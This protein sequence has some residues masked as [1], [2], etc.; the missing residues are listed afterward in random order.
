MVFDLKMPFTGRQNE[1]K[2]LALYDESPGSTLV[3]IRGRRRI[4]KS[5]LVAEY[6]KNKV[7]IKFSGIAPE[8]GM[9]AKDQREHFVDQFQEQFQGSRLATDNWNHLFYALAEK[10]KQNNIVLL[11]D[12]ISWMAHDDAT[13]LSKL[14]DF[15]DDQV[16]LNQGILFVL[17]SSVS[18]WVDENILGGKAFYGRVYG[19]IT[20]GELSL[21]QSLSLLAARGVRGSAQELLYILSIT[22][23]VPWY[24]ELFSAAQSVLNNISRLCFEKGGALVKEFDRIFG[25]LFSKRKGIYRDIVAQ[26]VSGKLRQAELAKKLNYSNSLR[27]GRYLS[28]LSS[29]G[30]IKEDFTWSVKTGKIAKQVQWRLSDNY[31]RFYLK[32]IYAELPAIEGDSCNSHAMMEKIPSIMGLQFENLVLSNRKLITEA[33]GINPAEIE[34]DNPY[35]QKATDQHPGCQIDYLIQTKLNT[36]YVCEIKFSKREISTNIIDEMQEK[37]K[38]LKKPKNVSCIPV[39]I[40]VNGISEALEDSGYFYRA[41]DFSSLIQLPGLAE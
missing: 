8:P 26:L 24:L 4:G 36:L 6:G 19:E 27:L 34:R 25:D 1:L 28:D 16:L 10:L 29:A 20:L 40:Y 2:K 31:L 11:F 12:E 7:F 13:F 3:V 32:Y 35:F 14:K 5:R 17:C 41:I 37:I 18:S 22:G 15:W 23:G 21:E 33:L 38:R 9:T 39:L 30:F